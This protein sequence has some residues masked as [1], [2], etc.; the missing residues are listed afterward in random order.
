MVLRSPQVALFD[1][2]RGRA[3][4]DVHV[5]HS[6]LPR[7]AQAA[8]LGR[9][10]PGRA[11][12]LLATNIAESSL[13]LPDVSVVVDACLSRGLSWNE[14]RGM[15]ALV[16]SFASRASC[17]QR[18]GRAG[19]VQPGTVVRL[20]PKAVFDALP[21]HD[22]PE[23]LRCDLEG[24]V[25][26][27]KALLPRDSR[28]DPLD[29][30][31]IIQ[32]VTHL[33]NLKSAEFNLK[34]R[35]GKARDED[36]DDPD[37]RAAAADGSHPAHAGVRALLASA[38]SPPPAARVDAALSR[39]VD[40]GA[41]S[42]PTAT[43][44]GRLT[45]LGRFASACARLPLPAARMLMLAVAAGYAADGVIVAAALTLERSPFKQVLPAFAASPAAYAHEAAAAAGARAVA[46]GGRHSDTLAWAA[47]YEHWKRSVG[48]DGGGDIVSSYTEKP[49]ASGS[50]SDTRPMPYS[51]AA[52][53][54]I[55]RQLSA[56][57]MRSFA[58]AV[59]SLAR[60]V[61]RAA[62]AAGVALSAADA[63]ALSALCSARATSAHAAHPP[64]SPDIDRP[65]SP[66]RGGGGQSRRRCGG[67]EDDDDGEAGFGDD[68]GEAESSSPAAAAAE[69]S[70]EGRD[71][72]S[73]PRVPPKL[74]DDERCR[75]LRF[76]AV[77]GCGS[78]LLASSPGKPGFAKKTVD[79]L[80]AAGVD[81][82]ACVA[83]TPPSWLRARGPA[84]AA[85][86]L[87]DIFPTHAPR[88]TQLVAPHAGGG[89]GAGGGG[90]GAGAEDDE[91]EEE[92]EEEDSNGGHSAA[93]RLKRAR[94]LRGGGSGGGKDGGRKGAD[95]DAAS[96]LWFVHFAGPHSNRSLAAAASPPPPPPPRPG[97]RLLE[98]ASITMSAARRTLAAITAATSPS[99]L[100][101][102]AIMASVSDKPS[103]PLA[104]F[105]T[106]RADGSVSNATASPQALPLQPPPPPPPPGVFNDTLPLPA[107]QLMSIAGGRSM[108][109]LPIL[110]AISWRGGG[111]PA[112]AAAPGAAAAPTVEL[113]GGA[114]EEAGRAACG[115]R[116]LHTL[117]WA[118]LG[119]APTAGP[120]PSP[121][122]SHS[123]SASSSACASAASGKERK[124]ADGGSGRASLTATS[125]LA[126]AAE[127]GGAGRTRFAAAAEVACFEFSR[128]VQARGLTLLDPSPGAAEMALLALLPRGARS[129]LRARVARPPRSDDGSDRFS[130][131]FSN[132]SVA[133][134]SHP[135]LAAI[136]WA[137]L[138]P[139]K[140][141]TLLAPARLGAP[142]L[143]VVNDLRSA[144]SV[145]AVR[146]GGAPAASALRRALHEF[147]RAAAA[148]AGGGES[149]G[150]GVAGAH[151]RLDV[152][153]W[154]ALEPVRGAEGPWPPFSTA[155][156]DEEGRPTDGEEGAEE[157]DAEEEAEEEEEDGARSFSSR[158]K[159]REAAAIL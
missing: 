143:R 6:L 80:A 95:D 40:A 30:G 142:Q 44:P 62:A 135:F 96:K 92:E 52:W 90:D 110:P 146:G 43:L 94:S 26:K 25:L 65:T 136:D 70:A 49:A 113:P 41:I 158:H 104:S 105:V 91:E 23:M 19:R 1:H 139:A 125:F 72:A 73:P 128:K 114:D 61:P 24:V 111:A 86:A 54:V 60:D 98:A 123:S 101:A 16:T 68:D 59:A 47:I 118:W 51:V 4:L 45:A 75:V 78:S 88:V 106:T 87:A 64:R 50:A 56:R 108:L 93:R 55:R 112:V 155:L 10:E 28:D 83:L 15:S 85:A 149:G 97:S 145:V 5:L 107:K 116:V 79:A 76:L 130:H 53:K 150:G 117:R 48:F 21:A 39:L 36:D 77:L 37:E 120:P 147:L 131:G 144:M 46:D 63:A 71:A 156:F 66:G 17:A 152:S 11:R 9:P 129:C 3:P 132:G 69:E 133:S 2:A 159:Q 102:A 34:L 38:P 7:E 81:A 137:P 151:A 134:S 42:P 157:D 138:S 33:N 67:G 57:A 18:A 109:P 103:P 31:T 126:F 100:L 141:P 119:G 74:F 140:P 99:P 127:A 20:L 89:G 121:S 58:G 115:V 32:A 13:T 122:S 84:A 14:A 153:P 124:G 22:P 148:A 27:A 8:A 35:S 154:R 82:A 12:V 29:V